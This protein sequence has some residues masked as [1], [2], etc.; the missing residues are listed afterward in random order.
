MDPH[1]AKDEE[2][3]LRRLLGEMDR[4]QRE[5][6][7]GIGFNRVD[8]EEG[9]RLLTLGRWTEGDRASARELLRKYD[10]QLTPDVYRDQYGAAKTRRR[11]YDARQG[12]LFAGRA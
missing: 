4:H 1:D 11:R 8:A 10:R 12:E 7:R 6:R 5:R 3:R 9:E 2:R